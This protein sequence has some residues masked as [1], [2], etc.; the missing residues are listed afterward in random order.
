MHLCIM[1][2]V[3]NAPIKIVL[4]YNSGFRNSNST[5]LIFAGGTKYLLNSA[6]TIYNL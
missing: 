5:Y 4:L 3:K 6:L 1:Y 2:I